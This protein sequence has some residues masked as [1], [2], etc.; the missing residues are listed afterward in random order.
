MGTL[1]PLNHIN[2]IAED[3]SQMSDEVRLKKGLEVLTAFNSYTLVKQVGEGGN[4][5]VWKATDKDGKDFAIK[6]L[7][8]H[9]S[10]KVLKRFKNETFFCITHKHE[11]VLHILDYGTANSDYVFY[12]MPL[13]TETLR[14]RIRMGIKHEDISVIFTGILNGLN[15]AHKH[16]VIHRDIKPENI[17][18]MAD[19]LLP[20]I[21]DFGIAHFSEDNLVTRIETR[22]GDRMANFQYAAPEQRK[23]GV[24]A[25]PQTDIYSAGLILNEMFTGEIPQASGYK[26]ISD[27]SMPQAGSVSVTTTVYSSKTLMIDYIRKKQYLQ[28]W[29]YWLQGKKMRLK[30]KDCVRCP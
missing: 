18:F 11:N 27:V 2:C 9:N 3:Y 13:Y 6:F 29:K 8:R 19:S 22:P 5:K 26:R 17:L 28:K 10:E 4:G 1:H 30:Q 14:D 16:G 25:V 20:V 12:V 23:K 15:F 21:A 7:E 24:A